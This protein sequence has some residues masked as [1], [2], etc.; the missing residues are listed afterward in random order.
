MTSPSLYLFVVV[1]FINSC[2]VITGGFEEVER[3]EFLYKFPLINEK[4]LGS[5]KYDDPR[6]D[7]RT[8]EIR[9]YEEVFDR[10]ELTQDDEEII[11]FIQKSKAEKRFGLQ[12]NTFLVC[13][14]SSK[15][16]YLICDDAAT[17]GG[18]RV[19]VGTDLPTLEL[20]YEALLESLPR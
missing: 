17:P 5:L 3:D 4:V 6:L 12:Q 10:T 7:L 15:W 18:D 2:A 16:N 13:L 11:E 9:D 14:R 20:G 8:L 1:F 19:K